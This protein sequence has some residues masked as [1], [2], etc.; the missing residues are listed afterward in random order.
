[1]ETDAQQTFQ[2]STNS[3]QVSHFQNNNTILKPTLYA[4]QPH[5]RLKCKCGLTIFGKTYQLP[6]YLKKELERVNS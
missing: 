4:M 2:N 1:M 5:S 6:L 3:T